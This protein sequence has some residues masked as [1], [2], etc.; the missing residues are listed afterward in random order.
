MKLGLARS[1]EKG[2]E[3]KVEEDTLQLNTQP[4]H[5]T[6]IITTLSQRV[7]D[8]TSHNMHDEERQNMT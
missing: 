7:R 5:L 4:F 3:K 6:P 1:L 2:K 8:I